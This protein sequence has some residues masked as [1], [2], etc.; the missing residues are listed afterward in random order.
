MKLVATL[1][2]LVSTLAAAELK[3]GTLHPLLADIA[4]SVGGE[5]VDVV[6]LV[7]K[8]ADPHHFEPTPGQI[9][10]AGTLDLCLASGMGLESYLPALQSLLPDETKLI[11]LGSQLPHLEGICNDPDH[12]H[13]GSHDHGMDPHWWHSIDTFRRATTLTAQAFAA[14]DPTGAASY[15]ANALA[16]RTKLEALEKWA[17]RELARVPQ[18]KRILPTAHAAFAYFCHDFGFTAIPVQGINREQMPSARALAELIQNLKEKKVTAIFPEDH[19]NPKILEALT[20]DTG[21]ELAPA[22]VA[23]GT[24]V[25]SYEEMVRHNV[26][27]IV[28][29]LQ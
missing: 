28:T 3:I 10:D 5:R 14:A 17:R 16:Y 26:R 11:D 4:K 12:H 2:T 19:S 9:R 23:D 15:E 25:D 20:A 18:D 29:A 8:N 24:T 27:T 7:G 22:L 6:E 21:I 1:L 13:H